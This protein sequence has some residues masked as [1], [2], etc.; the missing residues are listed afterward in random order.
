MIC[1]LP[2]SGLRSCIKT[3]LFA[4]VCLLVPFLVPQSGLA[5]PSPVPQG[6]YPR[7]GSVW[8][9]Q[10]FYTSSPSETMQ[11]QLFLGASFTPTALSAVTSSDAGAPDLL[12]V[13]TMETVGGVP[14]VPSSYYLYDTN[15]NAICNWPG[16]PPDYILNLTNPTVA[17]F[18]AQY[19]ANLL[20]QN[21]QY[22]GI[23]FDNVGLT[24]SQKTTDCNGNRISISSQ[25]N[26]VADDL[27]SLNNA[28]AA[29]IFTVLSTFKQLAPN[30]YIIIHGNQIPSD[31][32][33]LAA[34]DGDTFAFNIPEIREGTEAFGSQWDAYNDWFA[35]KASPVVTIQSS[36]PSQL[37]YG[38]GYTPATT[39]LPQ[40]V[41]FAQNFYPNMRFGLGMT[42]MNNG[43]YDFDFGDNMS[44][45]SW[46]YD[47]YGFSL[48]QPLG[49]AQLLGAPA[50]PNMLTNGSF[51]NGTTGWKWG[52]GSG[53]ATL[54][55]D[56]TTSADGSYSAHVDVSTAATASYQIC[57][58]QDG[59]QLTDGQE[60]Q[61]QFW[62]KADRTMPVQIAM[63]GGS[64]SYPKYGLSTSVTALTGWNHYSLSF[65]ATQS[66]TD[67]RLEFNL[68]AMAANVWIDGVQVT[69]APQRIY[70]RDFQTGVVLLNG[71]NSP[72]TIQLES[73][74]SR[75]SGS[76]APRWQYIV[77]DSDSAF[78]TT[79]STWAVNTYDTG[80]RKP[81]GP[82]Y[83]AWN[84]TL[85]EMDSGSGTAQ[86]NL[87]I[88]ADGTYTIQVWLP[89][90]PHASTWTT[91]AQYQ[92]S[93]NGAVVGTAT[94]NQSNAS[95]GDQWFNLGTFDLSASAN[96]VLTVKNLGSGPLIAD[97]V[98]VFSATD[99]Y[100][101]GQAVSSV[102]LQPMD[103][104]LLHKMSTDSSLTQTI[105]FSPL[106][107]QTVGAQITLHAMASSGL[108]VSYTSNSTSVCQV[109]GNVVTASAAGTCSIT[110][111]Q[112]GGSGY[113]AASPVTQTFNVVANLI[114]NGT[115]ESGS[116]SPWTF[117][118]AAP[119]SAT[120]SIDSSTASGGSHSALIDVTAA[121]TSSSQ[122]VLYQGNLPLTAGNTYA[123]QF[124]A[125]SSTARTIQFDMIGGSPMGN[126]GASST[127]S[128]GTG[129]TSYSYT[130]TPTQTVANGRLE[131]HFG[132]AASSVWLDTV[133]VYPMN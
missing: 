81:N 121:G 68:G 93:Q 21:P 131:F 97:A 112:A 98:Y 117:G 124:R 25:D 77:D 70:R 51:E 101:D 40:T 37:A 14:S 90:A 48:G 42:L 1:V 126:V 49:A 91:N 83:H 85:H 8:T 41:Q 82:Y 6:P 32:R 17:K 115:F 16:N 29:G 105:S 39:A 52:V 96:P 104:I 65:I 50:S 86:W 99:K 4:A 7:I 53:S 38:Y 73:G 57:L 22:N 46:W 78:S 59:L 116:L 127:V 74:L 2:C 3:S 94:L 109:S 84:S 63:Q 128:L 72:Q 55:V 108:P 33:S 119:A 123:I 27:V 103:A 87:G 61:V 60:Y 47:E 28:W 12:S 30:A 64:P 18:I 80:W 76:Q 120:A 56:N 45:V 9:G 54:N 11:L 36:P 111:S 88:P 15:G 106:S 23:F 118:V 20:S 24:I 19:A 62:A 44:F 66:A 79:G 125:K 13:N 122:V 102:T 71:T 10:D 110:A 89:K 34:A 132:N 58:E 35:K 26:G 114:S 129:W 130:F 43:F 107:T 5:Q 113:G 75:F 31:S 92:I 67:G 133:K 95:Q 69:Q 100:N